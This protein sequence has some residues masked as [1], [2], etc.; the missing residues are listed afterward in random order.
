MEQSHPME[1]TKIK[2][3]V[4]EIQKFP[5]S[6]DTPEMARN[7]RSLLKKYAAL[8]E[9]IERNVLIGALYQKDVAKIRTEAFK[10]LRR[11]LKENANAVLNVKNTEDKSKK[12]VKK[13]AQSVTPQKASKTADAPEKEIKP[14]KTVKKSPAK[15]NKATDLK[16]DV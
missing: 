6:I 9:K 7:A 16:E 15:P 11:K 3:I 4:V 10:T 1:L 13:A 8:S 14:K 2:E 12:V 5:M